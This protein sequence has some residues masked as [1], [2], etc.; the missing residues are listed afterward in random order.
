MT[1][2]GSTPR[3]PLTPTQRLKLFEELHDRFL[4]IPET[5]VFFRTK[6][7]GKWPVGAV[8]G[9]T[10]GHGHQQ[11]SI[12]GKLYLTHR[13]AWL[14]MTGCWPDKH[15]D[16]INGRRSDNRFANL[17]LATRAENNANAGK[18]KD[19]ASGFKGVSK[20]KGR[21][22]AQIQAGGRKQHIGLYGSPEEASAAYQVKATEL[23]GKFA[24]QP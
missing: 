13:L 12:K 3:K 1:D 11:I 7:C 19:N 8:A 6:A 4:Y 14:F 9:S 21:W 22:K 17:R 18:R 20:Q 5:G 23:F 16:H 10:D 2:V 15:I 24:R